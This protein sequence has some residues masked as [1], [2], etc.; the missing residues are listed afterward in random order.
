[1][2]AANLIEKLVDDAVRFLGF[3]SVVLISDGVG[4]SVG[5]AALGKVDSVTNDDVSQRGGRRCPRTLFQQMFHVAVRNK[6]KR[7]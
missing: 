5:D 2:A 1:M 6:H 3:L 4:G 7:I